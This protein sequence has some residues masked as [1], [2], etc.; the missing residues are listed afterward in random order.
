M[1]R[2]T[3]LP[4][5]FGVLC[6]WI[7]LVTNLLISS[8]GLGLSYEEKTYLDRESRSLVT[9]LREFIKL[10]GGLDE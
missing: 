7:E 1:D 3:A 2:K 10:P 4:I 9:A 6:A 8:Q 5:M